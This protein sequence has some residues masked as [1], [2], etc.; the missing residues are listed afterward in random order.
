MP[1]V[2]GHTIYVGHLYKLCPYS[3]A[4]YDAY[5][6]NGYIGNSTDTYIRANAPAIVTADHLY[7]E[8]T[9]VTWVSG[10]VPGFMCVDE[11]CPYFVANGKRHFEV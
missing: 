4:Y 11:D 1:K 9:M 10:G 8:G 2:K 5:Y 7:T 6:I 3:T